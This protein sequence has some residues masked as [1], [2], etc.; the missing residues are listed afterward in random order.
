MPSQPLSLPH[1]KHVSFLANIAPGQRRLRI[2]ACKWVKHPNVKK[3]TLPVWAPKV[4]GY[5]IKS[6][7]ILPISSGIPKRLTIQGLESGLN[8]NIS[9][10]LTKW[11]CC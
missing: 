11:F 10:H 8:A 4:P 9:A 6:H 2:G 1:H 5:H 7:T 3:R